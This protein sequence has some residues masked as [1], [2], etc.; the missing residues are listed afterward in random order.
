[1]FKTL[2][3]KKALV[4]GAIVAFAGS[5]ASSAQ[6]AVPESLTSAITGISSDASSLMDSGAPIVFTIAGGFV[7]WKIGKRILSKI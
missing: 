5:V 7:V 3:K 4:T 6:A 1:M 2:S